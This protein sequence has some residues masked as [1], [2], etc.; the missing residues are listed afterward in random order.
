M[1]DKTGNFI[2]AKRIVDFY[3]AKLDDDMTP[4]AKFA[5]QYAHLKLMGF[6]SQ[7]IVN[8]LS[9]YQIEVNNG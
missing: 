7:S 5:A 9:S 4:A 2:H 3:L 6:R 1:S 8:S